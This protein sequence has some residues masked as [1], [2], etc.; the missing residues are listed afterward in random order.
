MKIIGRLHDVLQTLTGKTIVSFAVENFT[1]AHMLQSLEHEKDYNIEIKEVKSKR[2][3]QQNKYMWALLH[4]IDIA[5]NGRP[6]DEYEIYVMC[7][8]RANAK[9]DYIGA[10]PEAEQALKE[11]F[12]A[13]KRIKKIS[14][15]DKEGYMYK[16]FIGSSKMNTKE[17]GNLIDTVLD[18]AQEVGLDTSYWN[19]VLK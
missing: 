10:L 18:V 8:E 7:L 13:V 14:L 15:N 17:M 12:R 6:T 11:N 2:T 19:E 1:H 3:L 16:V 4:E 5:M 9:F